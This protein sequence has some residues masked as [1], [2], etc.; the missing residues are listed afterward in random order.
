MIFLMLSTSVFA[1]DSLVCYSDSS[2]LQAFPQNEVYPL[3]YMDTMPETDP[4]RIVM[5]ESFA[6]WNEVSGATDNLR[7]EQGEPSGCDSP[8]G[9]AMLGWISKGTRRRSK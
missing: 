1:W 9:T 6:I 7:S 3:V 4:A 8:D 5:E 2:L